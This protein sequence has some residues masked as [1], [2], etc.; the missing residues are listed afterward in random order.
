MSS[1]KNLQ[2]TTLGSFL[3]SV[4]HKLCVIIWRGAVLI[5]LVLY[6]GGEISCSQ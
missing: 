5:V 2:Q 1:L 3:K 6:T 4:L